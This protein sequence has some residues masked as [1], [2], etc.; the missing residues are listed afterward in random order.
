MAGGAVIDLQ[1]PL[2]LHQ[3]GQRGGDIAGADILL[4]FDARGQFVEERQVFRSQGIENLLLELILAMISDR[5]PA[6]RS[7]PPDA[8]A[9]R[10]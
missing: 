10:C 8:P 7:S 9:R 5:G 3:I 6:G 2:A 4:L 1:W